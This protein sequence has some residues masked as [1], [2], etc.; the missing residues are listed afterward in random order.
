MT[1]SNNLNNAVIEYFK[2]IGGMAWRN[3]TGAFAG[4]YR[5]K[6]GATRQRFIR[7]GQKGSGDVLALYRGVFFSIETKSERDRVRESQAEWMDEVSR[8]GGVA[9]VARS[10]DDVIEAV[11]EL[12][13]EIP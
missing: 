11:S 3:N 4:Q 1:N 10:I 5:N 13:K 8:H 2:T 9:I 12:H 6:D 7:F